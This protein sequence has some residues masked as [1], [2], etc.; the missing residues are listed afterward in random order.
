MGSGREFDN[1]PYPPAGFPGLAEGKF[2][3]PFAWAAVAASS[4]AGL[5][6]P[7]P[8]LPICA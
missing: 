2:G 6:G 1:V 5:P 3:Q 4:A 8:S 7:P